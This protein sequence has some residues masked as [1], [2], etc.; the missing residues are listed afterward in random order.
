MVGRKLLQLGVVV[1][2]A[3]VVVV[4]CWAVG[5]CCLLFVVICRCFNF[6]LFVGRGLLN[7]LLLVVV[8]DVAAD[9]VVV[10]VVGG[11]CDY[12][13]LIFVCSWIRGLSL[14]VVVCC[15]LSVVVC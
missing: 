8:V 10:V 9:V 5:C 12:C 3:V 11:V 7:L 6:Y 15:L 4:G 1:F 13:L 14:S 2:C